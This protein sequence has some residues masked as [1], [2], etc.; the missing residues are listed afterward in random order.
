LAAPI[1]SFGPHF[2]L[3]QS[4]ASA[5]TAISSE[6]ADPSTQALSIVASLCNAGFLPVDGDLTPEIAEKVS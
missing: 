5:G 2:D 6:I 3:V 1:S 4:C